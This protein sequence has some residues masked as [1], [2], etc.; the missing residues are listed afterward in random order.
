MIDKD[1]IELIEETEVMQTL[2]L[3]RAPEVDI[4]GERR[5]K[6]YRTSQ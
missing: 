3:R 1:T 6:T 2:K 4:F 5:Y